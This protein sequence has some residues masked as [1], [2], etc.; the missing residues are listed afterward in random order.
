MGRSKP[1]QVHDL[2][3]TT[4]KDALAYFKT[5]LHNSPDHQ[6]ISGINHLRLVGL[7][8]RH[9]E[10]DQ[11]IGAGID[12]FHAGLAKDIGDGGFRTRCF[13]VARIDGTSTDF[14]YIHA[15][16]G[17]ERTMGQ[18]FRDAA[19]ACIQE[20]LLTK[21]REWFRAH[22]KATLC[23][24]TGVTITEETAHVDHRPPWTF[25]RICQEFLAQMQLVPNYSWLSRPGDN[26]LR[27]QIINPE[28][29]EAF[30]KFHDTHAEL[31]VISA[32][33]NLRHGSKINRT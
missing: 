23:P 8:K 20:Q 5:L 14:S 7:L 18:E 31:L 24:E 10:A 1:L 28:I 32:N 16:R 15:V 11:K 27:T 21:K 30:T 2:V 4:Q 26:Q 25:E 19:R 3:F 13:Y 33:Q 22:G 9:P 17:Q 12:S 6:K 29:A